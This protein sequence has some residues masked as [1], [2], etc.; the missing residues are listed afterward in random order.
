MLVYAARKEEGA[1]GEMRR[2]NENENETNRKNI[3]RICLVWSRDLGRG[4]IFRRR[5]TYQRAGRDEGIG[6]PG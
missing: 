2:E 4:P 6:R 5:P 1:G 3:S